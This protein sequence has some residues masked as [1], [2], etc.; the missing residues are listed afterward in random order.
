MLWHPWLVKV[1]LADLI[2]LERKVWDALVDG[3]AEA[4]T[5]LLAEEFIGI[6]PTGFANRSDHVAQL[7]G[8]PSVSAYTF[9][10]SRKLDVSDRAFMLSYR[11]EFQRPS[12]EGESEVMYVSSLWIREDDNWV[13]VFSQDTPAEF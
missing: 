10:D 2:Q 6:Y 7:I 3:D 1:S 12:G 5:E 9:S 4:D 8:G 13:N 11:A